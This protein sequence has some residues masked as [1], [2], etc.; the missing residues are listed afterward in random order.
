MPAEKTTAAAGRKRR[1]TPSKLAAASKKASTTSAKTAKTAS[2]KSPG[3]VASLVTP[4][5]AR[6]LLVDNG[7]DSLKYGWINTGENSTAESA[8]PHSIPNVSARLM[9]Q[10]TTL[11]GDELGRVQNPNSLM[12]RNRSMERG[13]ICNLEHQ[14]RVWKRMLDLLGV[15][16]PTHTITAKCLGWKIASASKRKT[17]LASATT[18]KG[19]L[20]EKTIPPQS[21]GVILLLPPHC[22]RVLLD[23]I[24]T[25]WME[26]F[27]V[28][29]VGLGISSAFASHDQSLRTPWK[30]S[31]TVDLGWSSTLV[32]PTFQNKLIPV[33]KEST[34]EVK[35]VRS[36]IRRMPIG[37]RHMVNMM[38]YYMS[39]RQYNLMDQELIMRDVFERLSYISTDMEQELK[40]ARLKPSGRRPYDRDFVLPDYSNTDRG[41]IRIPFALQKEMEREEQKKRDDQ[42]EEEEDDDDEDDDED[43]GSDEEE[44]DDDMDDENFD[45][46]EDTSK[47]A[48]KERKRKKIEEDENDDSDEEESMEE[49]RKRLLQQ[50][51]EE[52]RR[53]LAQQEEE[54]VLRV[55]VERFT[56]PEVLFRPIDAGL[57]SDLVG[58]PQAIVQSVQACPE[59]YRPALYRSVYLVGGLAR[60]PNLIER[61][62]RELRSL[63]PSEYD[64][65]IS[66]GESTI[67][68]AWTGAKSYFEKEDYTK[69]TVSRKEWENSSQ[70]QAY[71]KLLIEN[72]GIYT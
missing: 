29:H 40:I 68:R 70:R 69:A 43:F 20:P 31:C 60:L 52:H 15:M 6:V 54:Q 14:T 19:D 44:D 72:G 42:Q 51:V 34:N 39:Y 58:L 55:S 5:P 62:K 65:D 57:Q 3:A 63:V 24:F 61:L 21:I 45:E 59:Y 7:G 64:I 8:T 30:T 2:R 10:F 17:K 38:K 49:K 27:C 4:P 53:K 35:T 32:V 56:I 13:M 66:I 67:D 50:R 36:T 18:T 9:H 1:R 16:V 41:E 12:A 28:S 22:P 26:D 33:Q 25:V 48:K 46:D 11:V 71:K 23:Q 37:G 47:K